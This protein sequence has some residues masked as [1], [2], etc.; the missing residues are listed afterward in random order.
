[1][2]DFYCAEERL[3]VELDGQVHNSE[4]AVLRDRERDLFINQLGIKVLRFE[5]KLIFE[6][7]E[8][9]LNAIRMQFG[10]TASQ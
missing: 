3:A 1:M 6:A 2:L 4:T 10:W 5:N 9:V 7:T 8:G